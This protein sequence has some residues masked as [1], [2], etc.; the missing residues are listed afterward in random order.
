MKNSV[1][2]QTIKCLVFLL[3]FSTLATLH[4][5]DYV[6]SAV[7]TIGINYGHTNPG[8]WNYERVK[9][10]VKENHDYENARKYFYYYMSDVPTEEA[11]DLVYELAEE[12]HVLCM[13]M[14]LRW[15][16]P[17]RPLGEQNRTILLRYLLISLIIA[18]VDYDVCKTISHNN[19]KLEDSYICGAK[20][21]IVLEKKF[22][23]WFKEHLL[24]G[25]QKKPN[26]V[27]EDLEKWF[28]KFFPDLKL[29]V[30]DDVKNKKKDDKGAKKAKL[31]FPPNPSWVCYCKKSG[32]ETIEFCTPS[33]G[34]QVLYENNASDV[35]QLR[36]SLITLEL[37]NLTKIRS[38]KEFFSHIL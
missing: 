18:P 26:E 1:I 24:D 13:Y 10:Y 34:D 29:K 37:N 9:A 32:V 3:I 5:M 15:L 16:A 25:V 4:S 36:L 21:K 8:P 30:Q 20:V 19:N 35:N 7:Q 38:W 12:G 17:I 14:V 11:L 22:W 23:G 6:K 31:C 33:N 28:Q 27:V 2:M